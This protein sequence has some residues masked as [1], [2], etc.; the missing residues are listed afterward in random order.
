MKFLLRYILIY[1]KPLIHWTMKYLLWCKQT[2]LKLLNNYLTNR[3]QYVVVD[4]VMSAKL[5][6]KVGIPQGSILDPL[7]FMIYTNDLVSATQP[8]IQL[9][10]LMI[11]L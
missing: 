11:Q 4:D 9:F 5:P 2:A 3:T 1:Q 8:F 10:M 6:L 7:L